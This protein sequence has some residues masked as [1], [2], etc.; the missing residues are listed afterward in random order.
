MI[1][2]K[3]SDFV[4]FALIK[5]KYC[6]IR[7][8]LLFDSK[9]NIFERCEI[10]KSKGHSNL[11]CSSI[12]FLPDIEKII[13]RHDFD[14]PQEANSNIHRKYRK[15]RTLK[16]IKEIRSLE[17]EIK[18]KPELKKMLISSIHFIHRFSN[19]YKDYGQSEQ[20]KSIQEKPS[21]IIEILENQNSNTFIIENLNK[22]VNP[23]EEDED[24]KNSK[25]EIS[26]LS[27]DYIP[28]DTNY[29]SQSSSEEK[30]LIEILPRIDFQIDKMH[31]FLFYHPRNNAKVKF[32]GKL[33]KNPSNNRIHAQKYFLYQNHS[34]SYSSIQKFTKKSSKGDNTEDESSL[35]Q[36]GTMKYIFKRSTGSAK[37]LTE[38]IQKAMISLLKKKTR[39]TSIAVHEPED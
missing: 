28:F 19:L 33:L 4:K 10:C 9:R 29:L 37:N 27:K 21:E 17:G 6:L 11:N 16:M 39:Q 18:G 2:E 35:N 14:H 20:F 31:N 34:N 15:F 12:H 7:D 32:R 26:N 3:R 38:V 8:S 25:I 36:F 13:K 23:E 22:S 30:N 1:K 5:E 24:L